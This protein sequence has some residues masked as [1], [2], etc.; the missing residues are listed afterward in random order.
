MKSKIN[1]QSHPS[2]S[3]FYQKLAR[4]FA[5]FDDTIDFL[6]R[7]AWPTIDFLFRLWIAKQLLVSAVLLANGWDTAVLLATYEYPV[8]WLTPKLEAFLGIAAQF[9]GGISLLLGMF[10]RVGA[11][12]VLMFSLMTQIYYV[13]LDVNLFWITLM[14]GCVLRGPGPISLDHLLE[15]GFSR[16]PLPFAMSIVKFCNYTRV[17]FS[18]VYLLGLRLWLMLVL[19]L[20]AHYTDAIIVAKMHAL[21]S[22]LPLNSAWLIFG[23]SSIVLA[24]FIGFGF[25][26]R[27]AAIAAFII[28][29]INY[30][31]AAE[32][33]YCL[34][35]LIVIAT[36]FVSGPGVVSLDQLIFNYLARRYPQLSGKPAFSLNGLPHVVIIGAGFGGVACAKALRHSPVK[37]TLI[38][39]HNYHL[40]QPLLYQVA[41]G[42]LSPGD[43]AISIRSIFL[44]Q[45]NVDVMMR[46]VTSINKDKHYIIASGAKIDYDYLVIATGATHS[47]FGKDEWQPYA[48][49]LKTIEDATAVRSQVLRSFELAELAI[50]NEERQQLLNFVIVGAGPTGVE[51]AGAIAELARFGMEKDFRC[52]DPA[53]AQII[54]VQAAPRIL[55][56]FSEKISADAHTTLQGIGVKILIN[57]KVEQIDE[58]GVIVNGE[59]I[60]SKSVLWAAGVAASPAALWL[61]TEADPAGRVKVGDDLSVPNYPN[62]FVVGDTASVNA[63]KGHPL[64]GLAPAAKQ[65]GVYAASRISNLIN[66]KTS[67]KPFKYIHLGSLAT[68]GRKSAVAEFNS[69]K[70]SGELAWW[71]WGWVHVAFLVGARNRLSVILNWMWSY[72]TFRANNLLITVPQKHF[73]KKAARK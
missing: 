63:W 28:I 31:M 5:V 58:D 23:Q 62:I 44:S 25:A 2:S 20:V 70:I 17:L 13:S 7:I 56:T 60:Y 19:I 43:I 72:F 14:I 21:T 48:P 47:Y 66:K 8:S 53:T 16:S 65:G 26:T 36:L 27:L 35:W 30:S 50:T 51:L 18:R 34:Y 42:S 32:S 33:G 41:T 68:I 73:S 49:G 40:F 67:E 64:P 11:M 52:F 22:W 57:S 46:T 69:I 59:R 29:G 37:I 6:G 10:T 24:L 38:D 39:R 61:D 4:L 9:A 55:P 12:V 45:F 54:L 1:D 71:F 3:L 15:Q